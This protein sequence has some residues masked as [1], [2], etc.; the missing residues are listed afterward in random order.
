MEGLGQVV[1]MACGQV[2][3]HFASAVSEMLCSESKNMP[4][5]ENKNKIQKWG[6]KSRK[7]YIPK[8][9]W[10][11]LAFKKD[12]HICLLDSSGTAADLPFE[13]LRM[14]EVLFE[15]LLNLGVGYEDVFSS[16][17][18]FTYQVCLT[19]WSMWVILYLI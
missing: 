14:L 15:K 12:A 11:S 2:I 1:S 7:I 5:S 17:F 18:M 13:Y 9:A 8:L 3:A 16:T 10:Q 4:F 19:P 6:K